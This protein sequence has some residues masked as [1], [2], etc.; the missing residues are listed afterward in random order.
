MADTVVSDARL[1]NRLPVWQIKLKV[2]TC[3]IRTALT[4]SPLPNMTRRTHLGLVVSIVA[5]VACSDPTSSPSPNILIRSADSKIDASSYT[6]T[7][8]GTFGIA[9]GVQ[10]LG[11]DKYGTIRGRFTRANNTPGSFSWNDKDGFRDLGT[12]DGGPFLLLNTNDHQMMNGSV[13]LGP[14]IQRAA[15]YTDKDGFFYLDGTNNG[16]TLGSNDRGAIAGTRFGTGT[17]S[18]FIWTE[19]TG[20][21]LLSLSVPGRNIT[22][23]NGADVNEWGVIAGTVTSLAP[24]VPTPRTNA[25]VHDDE[26]G[27]TT[28]IPQLFVG[29]TTRIG[30][31]YI[32]DEGLVIGASETRA[33]LPGER[34]SSPVAAFPG[35][36]PLHAWKWSAALGLVDLGTLGGKYS[37]AWDADKDGNVYGWASDASGRKHAVKWFAGGGVIDL[38]SLGHDTVIGG[39]NKHGVLTGW[40]IANDGKS[41][42]VR[43]DPSK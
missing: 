4:L 12:F 25:F 37:V 31:T 3:T 33:P 36:V 5:A 6:V 21:Q 24:G 11:I 1:R 40:A 34:R 8:L 20:A 16:S 27:T 2:Q 22:A 28:L 26:T 17:S 41:H 23:S 13:L 35:D 9:A 15:A 18:A 14:G 32:S 19:K 10:A 42:A 43:F 7:D 39:L 29:P 30:V 38:G